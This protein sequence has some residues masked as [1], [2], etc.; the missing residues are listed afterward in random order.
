MGSGCLTVLTTGMRPQVFGSLVQAYYL[1][2]GIYSLPLLQVKLERRRQTVG[3]AARGADANAQTKAAVLKER[4]R[5]GMKTVEVAS[6]CPFH[7]DRLNKGW[8]FW[9]FFFFNESIR[10]SNRVICLSSLFSQLFYFLIHYFHLWNLS[11]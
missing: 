11:L 3:T 10:F 7:H 9:H 5:E 1:P 4:S 8:C 2:I 6:A